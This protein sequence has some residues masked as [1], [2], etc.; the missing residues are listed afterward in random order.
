MADQRRTDA[1][2]RA[3]PRLDGGAV[4]DPESRSEFGEIL[5]RSGAV[6]LSGVPTGSDEQLV[7]LA[8]LAG[9]PSALGNGDGLIHEVRPEAAPERRDISSTRQPFP[10]HTDSTAL[11]RPHDFICLACVSAPAG[12][13][14]ESMVMGLDQVVG[15][16]SPGTQAALREP[17]FP[18]PLNDPE[19]GQGVTLRAVLDNGDIRYRGD[20]L[21]IGERASGRPMRDEARQA[22]MEL[23]RVLRDE[24]RCLSGALRPGDVLFVDN[25]HALHGRTEIIAGAERHLR[26]LKIYA[27][28]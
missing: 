12:G 7:S 13:G 20:V 18:F 16:L 23:E 27:T 14:G 8:E 6:I 28:R 24:S 9:T 2:H 21:E 4:D 11:E 26:R 5:E 25:R 19:H 10:L 17:H 3:I 15:G 1:A 22:L